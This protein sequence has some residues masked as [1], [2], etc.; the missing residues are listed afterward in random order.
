MGEVLPYTLLGT[1]L[2]VRNV[3]TGYMHECAILSNLGLQLVQA[4][5]VRGHECHMSARGDGPNEMNDALTYVNLLS[6]RT[7]KQIS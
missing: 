2:L 3:S 7:V 5:W 6:G 1:G 4:A